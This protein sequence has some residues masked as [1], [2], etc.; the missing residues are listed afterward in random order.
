MTTATAKHPDG[1]DDMQ[2]HGHK[3]RFL[4]SVASVDEAAIVASAGADLIDG[5][6]PAAGA[7]GALPPDVVRDIASV[8]AHTMSRARLSATIGDVEAAGAVWTAAAT[9]MANAGADFVKIGIFPG[10]DPR[11][12]IGQ[13]GRADLGRARLVGVLLADQAPDFALIE[14]MGRAGFAGVMLDTAGKSGRALTDVMGTDAMAAFLA[15]ARRCGLFAGLA[16]SLAVR[17]IEPLVALGPDILGF[18]GALCAGHQRAAA[19]DPERVHAVRD[20][21]R[22]A[23]DARFAGWRVEPAVAGSI[24]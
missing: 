6:Q 3:V 8:L 20:A 19:L 23:Q 10:R 7:L 15:E 11:A 4:A 12:A 9:A 16:G 2:A 21:I 22:T 5:K 14:A 13:V 18:R 24:A 17:D 1:R